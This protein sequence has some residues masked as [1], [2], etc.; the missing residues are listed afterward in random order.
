MATKRWIAYACVVLTVACTSGGPVPM[1]SWA[2]YSRLDPT[3]PYILRVTTRR[4][5]LL[6]FGAAHTFDPADSQI[7]AIEKAWKEFRPDIAFTEGSPR[8]YGTRDEAVR[9]AGEPGLVRY[10]AGRDDVPTTSFEPSRAEELSALVAHFP[11]E[12][13]KMFYIL[14]DLSQ[15]TER[16]GPA[17]VDSEVERL[18]TIYASTPGLAGSP[19]TLAEFQ[20]AYVRYFPERATYQHVP[21]AWFDPVQETTFLNALSRLSASYRDGYMIDRLVH[22]V[23]AGRRVLAVVGGSHVVMQ[24]DALRSRLRE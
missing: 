2:Q 11:R 18:L 17:K 3:W 14:R 24:E 13:I 16:N 19:R 1:M 9:R 6:Y 10:L 23:R 12:Q 8:P 20:A 22:H 15:F 21:R 7:E 4:G 5:A